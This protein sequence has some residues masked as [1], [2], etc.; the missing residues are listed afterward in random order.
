MIV[1]SLIK[2]HVA[3]AIYS[4]RNMIDDLD[5]SI[6]EKIEIYKTSKNDGILRIIF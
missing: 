6:V 1:A 4:A 5:I 2:K 3:D